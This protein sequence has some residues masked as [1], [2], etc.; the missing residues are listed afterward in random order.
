MNIFAQAKR[1][2]ITEEVRT[3]ALNE[4]IP[5]DEVMENFSTGKLTI[6][7]NSLRNITPVAVGKGLRTKV[8]ANIGTSPDL[9]D[10]KT[11]LEK[12]DAAVKAGADAVMDLSTGGDLSFFRKKIL[13][14]SPIPLGTVPIYETA[15]RMVSQKK[16]MT[17]MTIDDFMNV[18]RLQAE[19]GVDFMTI[20]SGVTLASVK[21]LHSQKR[22]TGITSR[23]GAILAEW[24]KFNKRE[25]PLFEHY[26]DILDILA[27]Y[28]VV[29]SLGDGLRPGSIH[30]A[31]DRG[32]LHE[33]IILGDLARRAREKNVQ[34]IIEG[35]GHMPLDMVA[36]NIRLEKKL[37][38]D[39]PYYVLGPLVTDI[40][41]GYDHITGAI[42]GA[43]AASAGAD[44][45]CYVTPAEHL[46]LPDVND[47]KEGVMASKIAAHA[48]DI[49]KYGSRASS[50]DDE[51]SRARKDRNWKAMYSV[52]LDR[53]KAERYRQAVPSCEEDQCS[54]CGEF[55]S[56][57]RD[58]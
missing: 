43:I 15:V 9:F 13:E 38:D 16:S 10:L 32:Q 6:M 2:L 23:G 52:A 36:D 54:M 4:S 53:E 45:L 20:H 41:P 42:G 33:M 34:V 24:M 18:I 37:C 39:A 58:Y 30:D 7:K 17:E 26:D 21:S 49:V 35:P 44:F 57:K 55:C 47:V 8:N 29:I 40:A 48:G 46:R 25:N 50:R 11:E 22:I 19:E 56:M 28:N 27:Q 31:N 3:V 5:V 51:M 14:S 1:G 12:L